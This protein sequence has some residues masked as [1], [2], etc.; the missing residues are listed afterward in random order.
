MTRHSATKRRADQ[1]LVEQGLAESRE[2]A[3]RLLMAGQ[4]R[5]QSEGGGEL[6]DKPGKLLAADVQLELL[7]PER[8]V[9]RGGHK[10][11]TAM[12]VF[13]LDVRG[14]VALDA[15]ASTG[16]FSDCLLQHGAARVYA[17]DV[18]KP[19][20]HEKLR[21]DPRVVSIEGVNLRYAPSELL[22]EPVNVLVADLSFISLRSVLPALTRFLASGAVAVVLVKPQFELGAGATVKGVVRDPALQQEAVELVSEHARGLGFAVVGTAPS[23]IKGPKGNQEY[24]L[25]LRWQGKGKSTE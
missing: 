21:A 25:C 12:E 2:R 11:L 17:V 10:L 20:L 5:V 1:L 22:P 23:Q 13:G 7:Q 15:G 16:G 4:V 14:A 24:L 6:V 8:F 18:G 3:K 19:Q 9:S